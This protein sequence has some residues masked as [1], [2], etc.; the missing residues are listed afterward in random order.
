ME[1]LV[2]SRSF[3]THDGSF[4]ADE[5]TACALL[6][7]FDLI[8][9]DKIRRTRSLEELSHLEYVCDVGGVFDPI[10]KRFDH[11]QVEYSGKLSSAGMVLEYLTANQLITEDMYQFLQKSLVFG[12]DQI[13]NGLIEPQY[14]HASFSSI[15][16]SFVPVSYEASKEEYDEHFFQA[17][18]FVLGFL[19]RI[20]AKHTYAME[21]KEMV[22]QEMKKNQFCLVFEKAIPWIDV[23]F[24]NDGLNHPAKFVMM[25]SHGHWKLRAIP[26]SSEERMQVRV[27]L[28]K[29]WAGLLDEE[30]KAA[31]KIQGAIFCHKGRFISVW[32]TKQDA[33]AALKKIKESQ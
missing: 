33:L 24:E 13:D 21:C 2:L 27:P 10:K 11:H 30:L 5:V 28:P 19:K 6:L 17:L 1:Y 3:G 12:V 18:E 23:F 7:F 25:P 20:V 31:S 4:H 14:G 16:S 22:L 8:D 29:E 26:P 15:I 32:E 9:K